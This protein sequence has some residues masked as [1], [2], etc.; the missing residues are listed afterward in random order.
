MRR[1]ECHHNPNCIITFELN[2]LLS[3]MYG[4]NNEIAVSFCGNQVVV[5]AYEF[6]F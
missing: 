4:F 6:G 5:M 2:W 3:C 1:S